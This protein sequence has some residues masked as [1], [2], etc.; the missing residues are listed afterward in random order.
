MESEFSPMQ[1]I[2]RRF[3]AMRNGVVADSLRRAGSPYRIIFGLNLPQ[4]KE[5]AAEF[6]PHAPMLAPALWANTST[7]ES[8][9]TA[10]LM[11][12]LLHIDDAM[13]QRLIDE[14]DEQELADTLA[15]RFLRTHAKRLEI[16]DS[17]MASTSPIKH[18]LAL[19][20]AYSLV[21]DDS[22]R[23]V[24]LKIAREEIARNDA[25]T[26]SLARRLAYDADF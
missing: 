7:R 21:D 11:Y 5:I 18:Y 16:L 13:L 26:L 4:I 15:M 12:A 9:I 14:T 24:A 22:L 6:A 25:M 17:L 23:P 19:R 8:R 1:A 20:L 2:K 10:L 3:F